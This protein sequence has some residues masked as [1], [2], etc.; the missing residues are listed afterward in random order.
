MQ[1]ASHEITTQ[2][3]L[4]KQL[5]ALIWQRAQKNGRNSIS[6]TPIF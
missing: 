4:Q 3:M 6:K 2:I 1:F 5:L